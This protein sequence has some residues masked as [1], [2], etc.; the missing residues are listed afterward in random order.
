MDTLKSPASEDI[1]SILES[2]SDAFCAVDKQWRLIYING[3]AEQI[4]HRERADLLGKLIWDAFPESI[5]STF[6]E[7]YHQKS[8][9]GFRLRLEVFCV[10]IQAWLEIN[11]MPSPLG[12]AFYFRDVTKQ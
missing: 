7:H 1:L 10:Q 5:G 9:E 2:M 11:A 12:L 8:A 4:T 3:R 6:Y